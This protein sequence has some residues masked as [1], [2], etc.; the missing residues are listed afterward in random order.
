MAKEVQKTIGKSSI[1]YALDIV[2]RNVSRRQEDAEN[3]LPVSKAGRGNA[4]AYDLREYTEWVRR[5]TLKDVG[6]GDDG[7]TYSYELER[8]RLTHFQAEKTSLETKVLDGQLLKAEEV[9]QDLSGMLAELRAR[10]LGL[11]MRLAQVAI[12]ATSLK[13]I[14]TA[15]SEEIDRMLEEL[16]ANAERYYV[17]DSGE[18]MEH[19]SSASETVC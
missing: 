4:N 16:S 13:E 3:P 15:C 10:L 18:G 7:E 9:E 17:P 2:E 6:V 14:E 11:P 1:A 19:P 5:D 8:A 12:S